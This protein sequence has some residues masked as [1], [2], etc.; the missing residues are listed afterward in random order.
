MIGAVADLAASA[1]FPLLRLL[2]TAGNGCA[3]VL[4]IAR[5]PSTPRDRVGIMAEV[6]DAHFS[7]DE[8]ADGLDA[9]DDYEV[10]LLFVEDD[11][12]LSFG[13]VEVL[14]HGGFQGRP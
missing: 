5:F 7:A 6:T 12:T 8:D 2:L 3:F 11:E 13:V 10:R 9:L 1:A 14:D 4:G